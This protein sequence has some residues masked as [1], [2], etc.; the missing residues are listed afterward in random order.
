M[1]INQSELK[2][3]H[4]ESGIAMIWQKYCCTRKMKM[5]SNINR[6]PTSVK[7]VSTSNDWEGHDSKWRL[8]T[9]L[10]VVNRKREGLNGLDGKELL[11]P[12]LCPSLTTQWQ[13]P[14]PKQRQWTQSVTTKPLQPLF[15]HP[16]LSRC[17]QWDAAD[18]WCY[19]RYGLQEVLGSY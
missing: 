2:L 11:S 17:S 13:V 4:I 10:F 8:K 6:R 9:L 15:P 16:V 7:Q 1:Y 19:Q 3:P 14:L 5:K 18:T 12:G